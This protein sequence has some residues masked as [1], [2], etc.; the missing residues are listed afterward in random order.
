MLVL[1]QSLLLGL[2]EHS[3][4]VDL[5]CVEVALQHRNLVLLL[6]CGLFRQELGD[7]R[8]RGSLTS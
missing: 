1:Q 6:V 8:G 3:L 5:V 4:L 7:D 2:Y